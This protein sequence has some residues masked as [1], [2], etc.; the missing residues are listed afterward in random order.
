MKEELFQTLFPPDH[1]DW[2]K[3]HDDL[4]DYYEPETEGMFA[5]LRSPLVYQVPFYSWAL[6]N[7]S[8]E[9]KLQKVRQAAKDGEWE[10]FISWHERPYR[11]DVFSQLVR[12]K[13]LSHEQVRNI[14]ADIWTDAEAPHQ[15]GYG[16]LV[17]LFKKAGFLTDIPGL[18]EPVQC[19]IFRGCWPR[20][21]NGISWT[22]DEA[23]AKW[24]A[25]RHNENGDS[26]VYCGEV[27]P[28]GILA[29]F[30]DRGEQ[31]VV[32]DPKFVRHTK[33]YPVS[34]VPVA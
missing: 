24:F 27:P 3:L 16:R 28:E 17:R 11:L 18:K 25:G 14:L 32:V 20:H 29:I 26:R 12:R 5:M 8:Y 22:L 10:S 19:E 33:D 15:F 34:P 1:D 4:I 2:T 13:V 6:A 7:K 31:E 30:N 23:K 21:K 9:L